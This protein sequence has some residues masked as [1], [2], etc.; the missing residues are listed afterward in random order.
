MRGRSNDRARGGYSCASWNAA[1]LDWAYRLLDQFPL[2]TRDSMVFR[3]LLL[4]L[5]EPVLLQARQ[6]GKSRVARMG[7][8]AALVGVQVGATVGAQAAAVAATD[9]FHGK[10]QQNLLGKHV[11]QEQAVALKKGDFGVIELEAGFLLVG[12]GLQ[13]PVEQ[14]KFAAYFFEHGLE[15]PGADHFEAGMEFAEDANLALDR[16]GSSVDLERIDLAEVNLVVVD[17]AGG[18]SPAEP[19]LVDGE[20]VYV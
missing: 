3:R 7:L 2:T 8:A 14:V 12:H 10:S 17:R 6:R 4:L 19:E 16:F 20:F 1:A 15:A 5:F 11:G 9:D 13:G 18:V